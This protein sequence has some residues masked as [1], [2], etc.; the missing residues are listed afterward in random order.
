M[1]NYRNPKLLR[2]VATLPCQICGNHG[3]QASHSN[4][5]DNINRLVHNARAAYTDAVGFSSLH[6]KSG[7]TAFNRLAV[8]LRLQHGSSMGE[9]CGAISK[10]IAPVSFATG[11]LTRTFSP[12]LLAGGERGNQTLFIGAKAMTNLSISASAPAVSIV[13][14]QVITSSLEVAR[15]FE[16]RHDNIVRAIAN[17]A[18]QCDDDFRRLNF[19]ETVVERENPSGGAPIKSPAYNLTRD[20]FTLLAMGFTGKQ[21]LQFKLAY[22]AQFNAMEQSIQHPK[23]MHMRRWLVTFRDGQEFF[24]EI[25]WDDCLIKYKELPRLLKARDNIIST[26]LLKSIATACIERL[27]DRCGQRLS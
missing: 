8:F 22:I 3:T 14:Q 13:N 17:L 1:A 19:Q 11:L 20:G 16:K 6:S 15:V 4:Q 2:A 27:S 5:F 26:E 10:G 18:V 24:H 9:A 25:D 7:R 21:A 23:P 12:T